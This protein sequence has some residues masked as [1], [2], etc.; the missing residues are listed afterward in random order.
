[1]K[2]VKKSM[3]KLKYMHKHAPLMK[4]QQFQA[5]KFCNKIYAYVDA[6]KGKATFCPFVKTKPISIFLVL[7]SYYFSSIWGEYG[8]L[9]YVALFCSEYFH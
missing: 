7:E 6:K 1:M 3:K 9:Y 2:S 4:T 8:S 5:I